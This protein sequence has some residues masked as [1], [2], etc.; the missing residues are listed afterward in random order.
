MGTTGTSLTSL[1]TLC[2]LYCDLEEALKK[3]INLITISSPEQKT[4][5]PSVDI[6]ASKNFCEEQLF[7]A[8]L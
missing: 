5:M 3:P 6:L 7:T 8:E 4:Q 1:F 2:A